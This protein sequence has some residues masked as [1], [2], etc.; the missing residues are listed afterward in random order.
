MNS[1]ERR[2]IERIIKGRFELLATELDELAGEYRALAIAEV[3]AQFTKELKAAA[4]ADAQLRDLARKLNEQALAVV[5]KLKAKGI[6]PQ[7]RY[8]YQIKVVEV[9][10][11]ITWEP[12]GITKAK[13]DAQQEITKRLQQAKNNLRRNELDLLEKLHRTSIESGDAEDFLA[14]LPSAED[15]MVKAAEAKAITKG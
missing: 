15:L 9:S 5:D 13:Q 2:S 3:E 7:N 12:I 6:Q 8:G 10:D 4:E 11:N 1:T 14:D